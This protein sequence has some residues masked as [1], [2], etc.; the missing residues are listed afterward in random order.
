MYGR[1]PFGGNP[2][3]FKFRKRLNWSKI[4]SMLSSEITSQDGIFISKRSI[5]HFAAPEVIAP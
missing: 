4:L 3:F 5:Y 2:I 1:H